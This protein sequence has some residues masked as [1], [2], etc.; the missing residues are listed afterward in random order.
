MLQNAFAAASGSILRSPN[1]LSG[2][3]GQRAPPTIQNLTS[4]LSSRSSASHFGPSGLKLQ[5]WADDFCSLGDRRPWLARNCFTDTDGVSIACICCVCWFY[6]FMVLLYST[7]VDQLSKNTSTAAT[8][9]AYTR[10]RHT[11]TVC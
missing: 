9:A 11:A 5:P 1:A 8:N 2:A 7:P 4:A 6:D 10:D 3:E